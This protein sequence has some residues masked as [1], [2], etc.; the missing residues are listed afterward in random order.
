MVVKCVLRYLKGIVEF[1]LLY[2]LREITL[3]AC[4]DSD[5][6]DNLDDRRN[7]TGY[8]VFLDPNLISWS[9]KKQ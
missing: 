4:C 2:V 8:G 5:W 3:N 1:D 9:S 6:A 7:T